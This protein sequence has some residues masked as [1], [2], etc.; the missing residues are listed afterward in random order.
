[1]IG[2]L[3]RVTSAKVNVD[4]QTVGQINHGLLVLLGVEKQDTAQQAR[5]LAERILT[6]RVFED[7]QGKMNRSVQDV[8]GGILIVPQ[9]TLTADTDKGLRPG[10]SRGAA[11]KQARELYQFC[12]DY[13]QSCYPHVETGIFQT[14]M[15]VHLCNDG[16]ATF[17]LT[18]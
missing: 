10:F 16:P 3:Q 4:Q 11:P 1:M 18:V 5:R 9:F 2:L 13:A 15:K 14:E 12:V 6:Y 8:Q 17:L 7:N